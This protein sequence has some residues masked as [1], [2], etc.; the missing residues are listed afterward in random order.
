MVANTEKITALY[1][2]LSRDDEQSGDSNSIVNQKSMLQKYADDHSLHNSKFYLD[3]GVSGAT[4]N[5]P[6]FN[7]LMDDIDDGNVQTL[8]VKDMSRFGRDYLQVGLYTEI[9]LPK[10]GVRFI[11]IGDGVDSN[12][13]V[14]NDFTPF[15]NIINEWL[16]RDTSKKIKSVLKAKAQS[17]KPNGSKVAYGYKKS[18]GDKDAWIIDEPAAEIVREAFKLCVEGLGPSKIAALF[19]K[20]K[21]SA[22]NIFRQNGGQLYDETAC[23]WSHGGVANILQNENYIGTLVTNRHSKVSFKSKKIVMNPESEW[24]VFKDKFE[25]IIDEATFETVQRLRENRCRMNMQGEMNSVI[26]DVMYCSKCGSKLRMKHQSHSH[27]AFFACGTYY[28]VSTKLCTPHS[29]RKDILEK[30]VLDELRWVLDEARTHKEKFIGRIKGMSDKTTQRGAKSKTAETAKV[31]LRIKTL[32]KLIKKI[33]EDNVEGKISDERFKIM[34]AEYE[35]EQREYTEYAKQ[36]HTKVSVPNAKPKEV[37]IEKFMEIIGRHTDLPELSSEVV[38]EFVEKII[39]EEAVKDAK[40]KK[41]S[42]VVRI[43]YNFVG[44][45]PRS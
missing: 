5:R 8:V 15:R 31:D 3:D 41:I 20:R 37:N 22:P 24:F 16:C 1:C 7:L 27:E 25:P 32:D 30:L 26:N 11:A 6:G 9:T 44:E 21:L 23:N 12:T 10:A 45:I 17:G 38:N 28:N 29:I 2:R 13:P 34:L 18:P 33:Y 43:V 36:L 19:R 35:R 4:F 14:D 39:L 40:G 42:Q